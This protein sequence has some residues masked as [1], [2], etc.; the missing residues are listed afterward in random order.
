MY[1]TSKMK[2]CMRVGVPS[3]W[4]TYQRFSSISNLSTR[5]ITLHML[6]QPTPS[7]A[8]TVVI[9]GASIII[10]VAPSAAPIMLE[11]SCVVV[12]DPSAATA[13]VS[14]GRTTTLAMPLLGCAS[15]APS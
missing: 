10:K 11:S 6:T 9:D 12:G 5:L 7:G 3:T 13:S 15:N 8:K 4:T 1:G 2:K 14:L